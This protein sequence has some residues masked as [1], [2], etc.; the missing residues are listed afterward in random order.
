M[1]TGFLKGI[2]IRVFLK[3]PTTHQLKEKVTEDNP[4]DCVQL[5]EFLEMSLQPQSLSS[6]LSFRSVS[7]SSRS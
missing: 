3:Y 4:N 7:I 5:S 2:M 6:S 1:V